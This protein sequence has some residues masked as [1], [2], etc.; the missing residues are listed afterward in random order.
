MDEHSHLFP[1]E[2]IYFVAVQYI[3]SPSLRGLNI[4]RPNGSWTSPDFPSRLNDALHGRTDDNAR[5][6]DSVWLVDHLDEVR[7]KR[8]PCLSLP[9]TQGSLFDPPL[10]SPSP[11][12]PPRFA[13]TRKLAMETLQ[14]GSARIIQT[15]SPFAIIPLHI[16]LD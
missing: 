10:I 9:S 12:T 15:S 14:C 4:N 3:A 7:S 5:E 2:R 16:V 11:P 8:L 6:T 1:L 13:Q